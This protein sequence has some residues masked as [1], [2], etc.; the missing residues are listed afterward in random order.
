MKVQTLKTKAKLYK[1]MRNKQKGASLVEMMLYAVGA[2]AL[3]AFVMWMRAVG[4]P[5]LQ[6]FMEAQSAVSSMNKIA[7]VYNGSATFNG[8]TTAGVA[9][10]QNF[11]DKYLPGGGVIRNRWGGN[12]TVVPATTTIAD[13]TMRFTEGGVPA[14]S[15]P[16]MVNSMVDDVDVITVAG[17]VV[18]AANAA[19]NANTLNTQCNSAATVA[20]QIDKVKAN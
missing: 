18:K 5:M 6:G 15:C 11:A 19:V 3:L 2:L 20:I 4:W 7:A 16:T 12:I 13:D 10:R 1:V 9:N 17:T 8:M 14:G